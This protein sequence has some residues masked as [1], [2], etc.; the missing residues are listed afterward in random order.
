[1]MCRRRPCKAGCL[2]LQSFKREAKRQGMQ[3]VL[4]LLVTLAI[5]FFTGSGPFSGG[6]QFSGNPFGSGSSPQAAG[7]HQAA[8]PVVEAAVP[9]AHPEL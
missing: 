2:L 6:G 1:M 9:A 4:M 5:M 7:S 8:S 3:M